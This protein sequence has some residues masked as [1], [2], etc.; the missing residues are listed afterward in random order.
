M[1]GRWQPVEVVQ[2]GAVGAVQAQPRRAEVVAAL[3]LA[4]DL[5][6]GQPMEHMLRSAIIACR[7]A[8]RVG[9][10]TGQ[11]AVVYYCDLLAWIGC[12]AD[13]FEVS[14]IFGDDIGYRAATYQVDLSGLPLLRFLTRQVAEDRPAMGPDVRRSFG[15]SFERW[16]GTGCPMGLP[17]RTAPTR[18]RSPSRSPA[19]SRR[20]CSTSRLTSPRRTS[21][22]CTPLSSTARRP[23]PCRNDQD[24]RRAR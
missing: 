2:Q 4:L 3:S 1:A 5:G 15:Y 17:V 21:S 8:D 19:R 23:T 13:S 9:L 14:A 24:E 6:L 22:M 7:L 11:R 20:S 10:D 16:D 18:T 12:H